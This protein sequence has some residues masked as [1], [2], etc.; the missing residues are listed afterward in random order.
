MAGEPGFEPGLTESESVG[1]P[2]TYSPMRPHSSARNIPARLS[3]RG[4]LHD[5]VSIKKRSLKQADTLPSAAQQKTS[6]S[7]R[8]SIDLADCGGISTTSPIRD[9]MTDGQFALRH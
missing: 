3:V 5:K 6:E 2:L 7:R 8:R 4:A 1:L 9:F